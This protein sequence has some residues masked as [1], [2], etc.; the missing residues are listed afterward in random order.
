M[1]YLIEF[2]RRMTL[3]SSCNRRLKF[4]YRRFGPAEVKC[5]YCG[6]FHSTNLKQWAEYSTQEKSRLA[7]SEILF[8][9]CT[10]IPVT[11]CN[12]ILVLV[13]FCS[14]LC[15]IPA[16]LGVLPLDFLRSVLDRDTQIYMEMIEFAYISLCGFWIY[17]ALMGVRLFLM[18]RESND[19]SRSKIPPV[20]KVLPTIHRPKPALVAVAFLSAGFCIAAGLMTPSLYRFVVRGQNQTIPYPVASPSPSLPLSP[21]PND[22]KEC[23]P[24]TLI[25]SREN[26]ELPGYVDIVK[27][28][29]TLSGS[30]ITVVIY[31]REIP[32]ELTI[33]NR[34]VEENHLEM[35]W[36]I[37]MDTDN[38]P[39]TGDWGIIGEYKGFD[40]ELSAARWKSGEERKGRLNDLF[41]TQTSIWRMS[42]NI[43]N[44]HWEVNQA[45]NSLSL[46]GNIEGITTNSYITIFAFARDA[47]GS[48][49]ED[50]ICS[51]E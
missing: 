25:Q 50:I 9:S 4:G 44:G 35:A 7:L 19:Y 27:V 3:C 30:V 15:S 10:G 38:N 46:T 2:T 13:V 31:L 39:N 1:A 48:P 16:I 5:G 8:P 24:N 42:K 21:L 17:P 18:V 23:S 36:G 12:N 6:N 34:N 11:G 14:F 45:E 47:E 40:F 41:D 22:K 33:N 51:K 43:G 29:S 37:D 49:V 28:K 32:D 20:W 26:L